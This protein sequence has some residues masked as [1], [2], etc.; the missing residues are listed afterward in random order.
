[1]KC[2]CCNE[3]ATGCVTLSNN[4][5]YPVCSNC[6]KMIKNGK[7]MAM[8]TLVREGYLTDMSTM[9]Q[10]YDYDATLQLD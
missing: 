8:E 1:M 2:Y 10:A 5:A 6:N 4:I 7:R 3:P 9:E